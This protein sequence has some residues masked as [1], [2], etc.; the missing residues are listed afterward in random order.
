MAASTC[1]LGAPR[2]MIAPAP[3]YER[4]MRNRHCVLNHPRRCPLLVFTKQ[5]CEEL[6]SFF[7]KD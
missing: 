5:V 6:N 2:K 7:R 3:V 1:G 4:L